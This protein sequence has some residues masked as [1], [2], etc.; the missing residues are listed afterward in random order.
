MN[1]PQNPILQ[2][3]SKHNIPTAGWISFKGKEITEEE[4]DTFVY[5]EYKVKCN[6]IVYNEKMDIIPQ[7]YVLSLILKLI[8]IILINFLLVIT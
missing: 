6:N 2:L 7:P 4:T 1:T 8:V 3:T 5:K